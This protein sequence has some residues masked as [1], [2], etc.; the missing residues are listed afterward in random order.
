MYVQETIQITQIISLKRRYIS[1]GNL[2]VGNR[3]HV[4]IS[5]FQHN[6]H[7]LTSVGSKYTFTK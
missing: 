7:I 6:S 3:R 2:F 1:S 4:I 5:A